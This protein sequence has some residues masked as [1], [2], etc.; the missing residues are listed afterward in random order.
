MGIPPQ[1]NYS[2]SKKIEVLIHGTTQENL[3][4]ITESE[5]RQDT[6]VPRGGKS[7]VQEG[8]RCSQELRQEEQS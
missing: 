7:T 6:W 3:E 2:A 1:G 8:D 5:L 4:D